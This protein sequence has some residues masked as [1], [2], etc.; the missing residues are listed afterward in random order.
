MAQADYRLAGRHGRENPL[1]LNS[2]QATKSHARRTTLMTKINTLLARIEKNLGDH[3]DLLRP[4][5][6]APPR[7]ISPG[8]AQLPRRMQ[9]D[10]A[11]SIY[12]DRP[13]PDIKAIVSALAALRR[14]GQTFG[15][16][17]NA[18][19]TLVS[20]LTGSDRFVETVITGECNFRF[21]SLFVDGTQKGLCCWLGID[22]DRFPSTLRGELIE[23]KAL[24]FEVQAL[25]GSMADWPMEIQ[26]TG[27]I[28]FQLEL[29]AAEPVGAETV[30]EAL[31]CL[32]A[33]FLHRGKPVCAPLSLAPVAFKIL[34][35]EMHERG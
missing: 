2:G 30:Q 33:Q 10:E 34:R 35:I 5:P 25:S 14:Q 29:R 26:A 21:P 27:T 8:Y 3:P 1:Q 28:C 18:A 24:A 32:Y 16:I 15:V 13:P 11:Q 31:A 22:W 23:E 19:L 7:R 12:P 4:D 17:E 9:W 20:R 6:Q